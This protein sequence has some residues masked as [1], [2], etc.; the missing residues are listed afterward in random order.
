MGADPLI[1]AGEAPAPPLPATATR[2]SR[3]W[4]VLGVLCLIYICSWI[5]R[6]KLPVA[7]ADAK[8]KAFFHLDDIGRG[9]L[10]SAFGWTYAILQIPAGWVVDRF[11]AKRTLA[12]GFILWSLAGAGTGLASTFTQLFVMRLVLGIAETVVT[13]G[14]M[15]WI[16]Y[17]VPEQHRGFAIGLFMAAAKVGP[18]IGNFVA[19][20]FLIAFGWQRMFIWLGLGAL[21][22]IIPWV[23]LV[24]DA[25]RQAPVTRQATDKVQTPWGVLLG[26]PALWGTLVGTF[27]Y[28]YF[29]YFCLNWMQAYFVERRHMSM[30]SMKFA[31]SLSYAGFAIVAI[32]AAW[33]ADRR[34]SRGGDPVNVRRRFVMAGL[35]LASTELIGALSPSSNVA[36]FFAVFSLSGLGLATANYWALTQTLMP[37]AS[38]GRLVGIQNCAANLPAIVAPL[39]TGWLKQR[40]GGYEVPMGA[41]AFLLLLGLL[42]YRFVVRREY[43]P[44][45]A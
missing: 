41:A 24:E 34:I 4:V 32:L 6:V 22:C 44:R 27:G 36:L 26:S 20:M 19:P 16:R 11:G 17:N 1:R 8:F 18:A 42:S 38:V 31:A 45:T 40:T 13:P 15:R 23:L 29:N 21:V 25:D 28:Q 43:A 7:L 33:A 5:D 14:G 3:S 9:W 37:G 12:A 10:N 2:T 39:L 30:D 35:V